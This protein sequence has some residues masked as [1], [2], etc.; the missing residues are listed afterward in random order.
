MIALSR[1]LRVVRTHKPVRKPGTWGPL[2]EPVDP[3]DN[4]NR[5]RTQSLLCG[6]VYRD[7]KTNPDTI[8]I[9]QARDVLRWFNGSAI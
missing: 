7:G 4:L 8:T 6:F 5:Y 2:A 1:R 9:D 3:I